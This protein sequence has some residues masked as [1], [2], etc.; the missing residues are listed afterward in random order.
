MF[1]S[2]KTSQ[3]AIAAVSFLAERY[4]YKSGASRVSSIEIAEARNLPKPI[5]AKI[6][7]TLSQ[8]GYVKGSPGPGGGYR[9]AFP[10]DEISFFDVV[11]RFEE[12]GPPVMCPFGPEWCGNHNPCPLHDAIAAL[13]DTMD[14]FLRENH[15]GMF[16][17]EKE[18]AK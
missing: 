16:V 15:F 18:A 6:L 14:A 7:T 1:G 8:A 2:G 5:V 13:G 11:A 3:N 17:G 10:P 9:L 4:Y 12:P